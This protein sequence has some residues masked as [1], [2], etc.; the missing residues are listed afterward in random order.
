MAFPQVATYTEEGHAQSTTITM[1]YPASCASGD[2]IIAIL[3]TD[4]D[5]SVSNYDVDDDFTQI[6]SGN[7]PSGK[8]AHLSVA[9]R[10]YD[11]TEGSTFRWTISSSEKAAS[12]VFRITGADTSTNLPEGT[13]TQGD[14]ANPNPPSHD[15]TQ[16]TKDYLWIAC[17][18]A[19]DDDAATAWPYADNNRGTTSADPGGCAV[20]ACTDELTGDT[21]D[22]G[23]FTIP[24]TEEWVAATIAVFPFPGTIHNISP[25]NSAHAHQSQESSTSFTWSVSP[26]NSAH[27][28]Q[29]E[30]PTA[31]EAGL[32][33]EY[34][35]SNKDG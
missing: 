25:D 12:V 11:G 14:N 29:S 1:T 27:A 35:S 17:M 22:P 6:V 28:H 19:D 8:D 15:T 5:N 2:L 16:G 13:L 4:G 26:D 20:A 33:S 3:A 9:Y 34:P 23:T 30:E 10:V 7:D 31:G 18:G 32:F 24:A 21:Q